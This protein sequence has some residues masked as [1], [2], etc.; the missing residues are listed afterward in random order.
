MRRT[1]RIKHKIGAV[2]RLRSMFLE[3]MFLP[4]AEVA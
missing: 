3:L 2:E 1:S 4:A